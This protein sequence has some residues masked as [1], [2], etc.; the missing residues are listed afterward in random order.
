VG[1][2]KEQE[3]AIDVLRIVSEGTGISLIEDMEELTYFQT[4]LTGYNRATGI[5]GH[6]RKRATVIHGPNQVGKSVLALALAESAR[7][8]GD[9]A[10][11]F[12]TEYA[13]E[14]EWYNAISPKCGFH[15][16]EDLDELFGKIQKMLDNLEK[17]KRSKSKD[18]KLSKDVGCFFVVDTL[19]KLFPKNILEKIEKEGVDKMYPLQA[20]YISTWMKSLI[21]QLARTNSDLVLVMQERENVNKQG[22]FDKDYKVTGGKAVMYDNCVRVRVTSASRVKKGD[23]TVGSKIRYTVE[24]NK[25]DG[26]SFE[27]SVFFTSNG[28]GDLPKGL[29]LVAEAVE[30]MKERGSFRKLKRKRKGES[31]DVIEVNLSEDEVVEIEGGMKDVESYFRESVEDFGRFVDNLNAEA[32]RMS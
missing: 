29:D 31:V 16:P 21:P 30:E 15:Q 7:R 28:K 17:A 32:R 14:R 25:V 11:V 5:G 8:I 22:F 23:A 2:K 27:K 24:N 6:P 19:T 4:M 18:S 9:A 3:S 13:G 12:D 10:V 26:T 20:A 1:R